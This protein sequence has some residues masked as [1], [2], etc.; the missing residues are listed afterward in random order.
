MKRL[1]WVGKGIA[2]P[3]SKSTFVNSKICLCFSGSG[4]QRIPRMKL[5]SKI[6]ALATIAITTYSLVSCAAPSSFTYQNVA[7]TL[8]VQC[9]DCPTP[10]YNPAY[11]AP[12]VVGNPAPAGSVLLVP[13]TGQ[14][15]TVIFTATVT[16]APANVTWAL[17]PNPNLGVPNP[18]PTGT[19][20]PVTES[21]P[22]VGT[23]NVASGNTA[24]YGQN[25]VPVYG[26][27]ALQQAQQGTGVPAGL[28]MSSTNCIPQGMV[29]LVASVP[30]DP[31]N[32]SATVSAGQFIQIYGG[33]TAQGPPSVYL[34]P[35]TPTVPS[36]LTNPV[37]TVAHNGGTYQFYGGV[38][39]A[40]PCIT[41]TTCAAIS[42]TTPLNTT[43]NTA[44]WEVGPS[45]YSLSTAVPGG[46]ATY[47]TISPTGLYTAPVD[48]PPVQPVVILVSHLVP[49][50]SKYAY[51]AVN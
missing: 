10:I 28:C 34:T 41:T 25:G 5:C 45:P 16:N 3:G 19:T 18:P 11:P 1:K 42:A 9:G 32:P 44:I 7:V 38:V 49:T 40:A 12:A 21:T 23:I 26:G 27:P 20:T 33:S 13:A 8:S 30:S 43:D 39:G 31:N 50:V 2:P 51:I 24:Y 36:G 4:L 22:Q 14:G 37:A 47:G 29:L 46:S 15:G 48:V 6:L 17:Y 35:S